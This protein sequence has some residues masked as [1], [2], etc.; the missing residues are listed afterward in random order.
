MH[1]KPSDWSFVDRGVE[2][3][4]PDV[5][6]RV[7]RFAAMGDFH[8]DAVALTSQ[9]HDNPVTRRTA[10]V[11]DG[12]GDQLVGCQ[13]Q[14]VRRHIRHPVSPGEL[15]DRSREPP[16]FSDIISKP[17]RP[18]RGCCNGFGF[19]V[20]LPD[21]AGGNSLYCAT[22]N[23]VVPFLNSPCDL[24]F[25]L[26]GGRHGDWEA[27][28]VNDRRML[29]M[30]AVESEILAIGAEDGRFSGNILRLLA[31]TLETHIADVRS[32]RAGSGEM[33]TAAARTVAAV[34]E[35]LA[36]NLCPPAL[37]RFAA[38]MPIAV[39]DAEP[40]V[41][42][43]GTG[44][45]YA[46]ALAALFAWESAVG[47]DSR[48][49]SMIQNQIAVITRTCRARIDSHLRIASAEDIPDVRLLA[50]DILRVEAVEWLIGIA[51]GKAQAQPLRQLAHHAARQA[52][53]WAGKVFARFKERPDEF[54]HFDA[55]AT[56][57]A[58]D[59]LL[60]VILRVLESDREDRSQGS[61]PFV[62]TVGE[63]ALQA[64]IDGM[65]HMTRRYLDIAESLLVR[66]GIDGS[67]LTSVLAV[68]HRIL[69][70]GH[71]LLPM[72]EM[73]EV[74]QNHE[75]ALARMVAMRSKLRGALTMPGAS[76][77]YQVRLTVIE[78]ALNDLGA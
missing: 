11:L 6:R 40:M 21:R 43:E 51:G 68:L 64:F 34:S 30:A 32:V 53:I 10:T 58:V 37:A 56:L 19:H 44:E 9:R 78:K 61:H 66:G 23:G 49:R 62:M 13:H 41:K 57:S 8:H 55:V 22:P 12:V 25:G 72:V 20:D 28:V 18:G 16:N 67:F 1:A 73:I 52:V 2:I 71:A 15:R 29:S 74:R 60:V 7:E 39:D 36:R 59:D 42:G 75:A 4:L 50:R 14:M 70:L 33:R 76:A 54:S 31:A 48:L 26:A 46:D 27:R 17:K 45:D 47:Q 77:D 35:H 24:G 65:E 63:Q 5:A 3:G 38:L 69:R